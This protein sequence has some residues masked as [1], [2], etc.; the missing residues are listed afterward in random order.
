MNDITNT[1]LHHN[2]LTVPGIQPLQTFTPT[3]I[4][5]YIR[6]N[7]HQTLDESLQNGRL[8]GCHLEAG[9]N[10]NMYLKNNYMSL[11]Y[12]Q[13][14]FPCFRL[15]MAV[16]PCELCFYYTCTLG[17]KSMHICRTRRPSELHVTGCSPSTAAMSVFA[18]APTP[19]S[20]PTGPEIGWSLIGSPVRTT[21]HVSCMHVYA[22]MRAHTHTYTHTHTHTRARARAHTATHASEDC[23]TAHTHTQ[24][25]VSMHTLL[26]RRKH[27]I[28]QF[29]TYIYT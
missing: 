14:T 27:Q 11:Q 5:T 8:S 7:V 26:I 22:H 23:S 9:H 24:A 20:P 12:S 4:R 21:G 18:A 1:C 15:A 10:L 16:S 17:Q 28:D 2:E 19:S 29:S 25:C 6:M 13:N 3:C